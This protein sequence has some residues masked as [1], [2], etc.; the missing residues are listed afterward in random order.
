M[1]KLSNEV[2]LTINGGDEQ[3]EKCGD[4][5]LFGYDKNEIKD[6]MIMDY[7]RKLK[8]NFSGIFSASERTT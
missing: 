3:S 1:Y 6:N 7:A 4:N 8:K 2:L 5:N